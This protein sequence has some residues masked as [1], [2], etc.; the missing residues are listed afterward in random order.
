MED[1]TFL[2]AVALLVIGVIE[3]VALLLGHNGTIL[4][5]VFLL[6]GGLV[7]YTATITIPKLKA[8]S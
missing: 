7:G 6:I 3:V 2:I 5:S 1:K 4:T 8:K